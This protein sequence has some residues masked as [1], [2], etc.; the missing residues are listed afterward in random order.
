MKHI[1]VIAALLA[2]L[3]AR[4]QSSA[5]P[6]PNPE[7]QINALLLRSA[8]IREEQANENLAELRAKADAAL[9]KAADDLAAANARA[10]A[11]AKELAA[12]KGASPAPAQPAPA[13]K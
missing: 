3:A 5:P 2:P 11:A 9:K 10:D 1:V 6:A 7:A 8:L 13:P 12:L 4:A